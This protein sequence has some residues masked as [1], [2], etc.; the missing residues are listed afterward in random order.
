MRPLETMHLIKGLT[1]FSVPKKFHLSSHPPAAEWKHVVLEQLGS[2]WISFFKTVL[3][4][5]A[6]LCK[7]CKPCAKLRLVQTTRKVA[8]LPSAYRASPAEFV[9][10]VTL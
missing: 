7:I 5:S 1:S 9:L 3:D 2:V 4:G 6:T 10:C 8:K